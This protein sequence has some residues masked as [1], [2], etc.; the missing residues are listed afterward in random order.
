[1]FFRKKRQA[2]IVFII[3]LPDEAQVYNKL[4]LFSSKVILLD[5]VLVEVRGDRGSLV[6]A[7]C[8]ALCDL[9]A[10][11]AEEDGASSVWLVET[12]GPAR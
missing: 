10:G 7:S 11:R 9:D 1:M 3:N 8:P 4:I 5:Y 12:A 2:Y 6:L